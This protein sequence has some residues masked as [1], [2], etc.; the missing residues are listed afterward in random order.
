MAAT[1]LNMFQATDY[2]QT[3]A[4]AAKVLENGGL[5]VLPTE[6]LYG[7]AGSLA[8][9]ETRSR[10]RSLRPSNDLKPFTLHL[11]QAEDAAEYLDDVGELAG[12]MMRKLWPGPVGLIFDVS[13]SRRADIC[14]KLGIEENELFADGTITLRCPDHPLTREILLR[15]GQPIVLTGLGNSPGDF[16]EDLANKV[17]LILDA[18]PT[19]YSKPSTLVRIYDDRYEIVRKGVFDERILQRL[20]HT[21][22]LF[23]CS[24]N[25]CRSPM[26]A[27]LARQIISENLQVP[28]DELD[29]RGI[30][31]I[32]AGTFAM[33]GNRA[34]TEAI[35][36]LHER[37]ID[38]TRHRSQ[39]V[40]VELIHQADVIYVMGQ[41]HAHAIQAMVPSA[42]EKVV[43]LDP[44][45]DVED[46]IG[47][48][49]SVYR[50]LAG[51][52]QPMIEKRLKEKGV[53]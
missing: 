49:V 2:G 19:K 11:A 8:K 20:L 30:S 52:L 21:T 40:T 25:T 46:P 23:L 1:T 6:T 31:V 7:A 37:G 9:T 34:T 12:R 48:D 41:S 50:E 5:A 51:K 26:A 32:S 39:P 36:T 27:A 18:G 15:S 24:G 47:S 10:M 43:P 53:I 4:Q 35:E 22:I 44:L 28:A 33:A 14:K 45:R 3:I 38:L 42:A 29:K 13:E 17:D 16:E